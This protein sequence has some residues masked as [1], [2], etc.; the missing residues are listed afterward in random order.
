V[1]RV[2]HSWAGLRTFA[3]DREPVIGYDTTVPGLFWCAGQGGYGIQ[4]SPACAQL[5]AA[6]ARGEAVPASIA[7]GGVT[8]EAVSP[9]RF[10]S[11]AADT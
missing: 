2:R 9:A 1:R 8:A 6:V 11:R 3:P 10:S 5:A 7:A 4:S